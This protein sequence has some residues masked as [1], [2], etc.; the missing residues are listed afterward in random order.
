LK[1]NA[2]MELHEAWHYLLQQIT[3]RRK[4][5][6]DAQLTPDAPV[7]LLIDFIDGDFKFAK[8]RANSGQKSLTL[9]R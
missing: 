3:C 2:R 5:S 7:L 4:R 8:Y 6:I 1:L 9:Q